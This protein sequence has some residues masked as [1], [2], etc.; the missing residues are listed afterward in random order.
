M[1]EKLQLLVVPARP[2]YLAEEVFA[3]MNAVEPG[4]AG[5]FGD[6]GGDPDGYG[7]FLAPVDVFTAAAVDAALAAGATVEEGY[8]V[9]PYRPGPDTLDDVCAAT[10]R[11]YPEFCGYG[12][13]EVAYTL[14]GDV[15]RALEDTATEG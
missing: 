7:P 1:I 11:L 3:A 8:A 12:S 6:N 13:A 10:G 15:A 5:E 14:D 2:H 9:Y 4:A